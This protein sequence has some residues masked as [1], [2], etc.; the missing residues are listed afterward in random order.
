MRKGR[1]QRED[2]GPDHPG[3]KRLKRR[4]RMSYDFELRL[5]PKVSLSET[6]STT[7]A[8]PEPTGFGPFADRPSLVTRDSARWL[9]AR[10]I[11]VQELDRFVE[12]V[13][14][15]DRAAPILRV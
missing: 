7:R 2:Y 9:A 11:Q 15:N 8:S 6:K 5:L 1:A 14:V 4:P 3:C 10:H 12:R 13:D